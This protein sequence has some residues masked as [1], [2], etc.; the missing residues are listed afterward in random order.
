MLNKRVDEEVVLSRTSWLLRRH[1]AVVG[2]VVGLPADAE[3]DPGLC[4]CGS[5]RGIQ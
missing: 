1:D 3:Q 5:G 2:Q 4:A